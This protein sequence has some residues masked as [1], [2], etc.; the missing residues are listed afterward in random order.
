[1]LLI[2][3]MLEHYF[4]LPYED[5]TS[6]IIVALTIP[7]LV[8]TFDQKDL[9]E[10]KFIEANTHPDLMVSIYKLDR[11]VNPTKGEFKQ[12]I[13]KKRFVR[14]DYMLRRRSQENESIE[15][16]DD[17]IQNYLCLAVRRINQIIFRNVKQYDED[18]AMPE[19]DD[20]EDDTTNQTNL[21]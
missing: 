21:P 10:L 18:F 13:N 11:S 15:L 17:Q 2:T 19:M 5:F 12:I 7:D 20:E 6:K 3:R 4:S 14:N 8:K 1:M 9:S 16:N